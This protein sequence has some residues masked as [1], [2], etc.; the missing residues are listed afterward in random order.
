[1]QGFTGALYLDKPSEI[2]RYAEAFAVI[3][4][5]ALPQQHSSA[6]FRRTAREMTRP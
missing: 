3:W 6:L 5:N 4:D 2:D 1:V